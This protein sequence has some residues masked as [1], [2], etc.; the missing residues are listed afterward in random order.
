MKGFQKPKRLACDL[1]T[2]SDNFGHFYAQPFERGFGVTVGNSLRRIL[3]S[4][5]EGYAVS[6]VRIEGVDH[7]FGSIPGVMED[8]SEIILNIKFSRSKSEYSLS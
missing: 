1:E 3:I 8:A 6:S 4:S 5:M 2:L 7:E